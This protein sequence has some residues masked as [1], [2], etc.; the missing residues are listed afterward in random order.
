MA[1]QRSRE[2]DLPAGFV[3]I[4]ISRPSD[5]ALPAA[6]RYRMSASCAGSGGSDHAQV[7]DSAE[8]IRVHDDDA[9]AVE[10][11]GWPIRESAGTTPATKSAKRRHRRLLRLTANGP[12]EP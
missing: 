12:H 6:I 7:F 11:Q 2:A 10:K 5:E 4:T 8:I 3:S 9:V 1:L